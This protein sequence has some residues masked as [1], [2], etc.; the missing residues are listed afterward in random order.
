MWLDSVKDH[1]ELA[2]IFA[3]SHP[4]SLRAFFST[5]TIIFSVSFPVFVFCRDG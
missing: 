3:P 5:S 2:D 1:S 4:I